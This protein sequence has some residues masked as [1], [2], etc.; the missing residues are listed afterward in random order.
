MQ[1]W[2]P[3]H[4]ATIDRAQL[5]P[6]RWWYMVA[7]LIA[8][9][10]TLVGAGGFALGLFTAVGEGHLGRTFGAGQPVSVRLQ[11]DPLPAIFVREARN[12]ST[13]STRCAVRTDAGRRVPIHEPSYSFT[14]DRYGAEWRLIYVVNP[15]Q[16]GGYTITCGGDGSERFA[17]GSNP[18]MRRFFGGLF[19]ALFAVFIIPS[20]GIFIGVIIAIVV[21]VRRADARRRLTVPTHPYP[22]R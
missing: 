5:R 2:T 17:V 21:A 22:F 16:S 13:F 8:V 12:L 18:D 9:L 7:G 10:G 20:I 11:T 15:R 14:I 1:P 4:T 3:S 19:G 6:R